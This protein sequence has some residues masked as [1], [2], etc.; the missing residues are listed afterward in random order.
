[1][2][3]KSGALMRILFVIYDNGSQ[4]NDFPLGVTYLCSFLR[5]YWYKDIAIY[6]QDIFH[7]PDEHLTNFLNNNH[8]DIVGVGVIGGYYQ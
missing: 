7:F 1:M 5:Q 3:V 2:N 4:T 6:N 8:F